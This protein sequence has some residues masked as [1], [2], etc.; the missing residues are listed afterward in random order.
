VTSAT[1]ANPTSTWTNSIAR[2]Y[3]GRYQ[4]RGSARLAS[5][6][7]T[8][9]PV[10]AAGDPSESPSGSSPFIARRRTARGGAN[11][12]N[13]RCRHP[14]SVNTAPINRVTSAAPITNRILGS[15]AKPRNVWPW[16]TRLITMFANQMKKL[17]VNRQPASTISARNARSQTIR[18]P[19]SSAMGRCI[20][21]ATLSSVNGSR[22]SQR[23]WRNGFSVRPPQM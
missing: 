18:P 13:L 2:A 16:Y 11:P 12:S 4:N 7:V 8:S 20:H 1:A 23:G 22:I 5:R 15:N 14:A 21:P 19:R 6:A 3:A 17:A 9:G 10:A